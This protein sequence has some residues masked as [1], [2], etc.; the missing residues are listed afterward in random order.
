[1]GAPFASRRALSRSFQSRQRRAFG[2]LAA[3]SIDSAGGFDVL[4]VA[5]HSAVIELPDAAVAA[6]TATADGLRWWLA[7]LAAAAL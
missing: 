4:A 1:M 5:T 6:T 3:L 7:Q 2:A